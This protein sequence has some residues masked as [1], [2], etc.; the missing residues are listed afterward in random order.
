MR[1]SNFTAN[2]T[3]S[4]ESWTTVYEMSTPGQQI[5][6]AGFV[7]QVDHSNFYLRVTVND[8]VRMDVD[9][10]EWGS[11]SLLDLDSAGID[12]IRQYGNNRWCFKF[13]DLV[14]ADRI[15]IEL[16]HKTHSN[17]KLVRGFSIS[18]DR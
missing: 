5:R 2:Q 14:F 13:P 9:L 11:T 1:I 16:K 17:K 12:W 4:D 7:F 10:E 8:E 15:K 6:W 18:L 3:I